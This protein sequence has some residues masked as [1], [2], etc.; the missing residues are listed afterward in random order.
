[1]KSTESCT[2][3][4]DVERGSG[5]LPAQAE[6]DE[7]RIEGTRHSSAALFCCQHWSYELSDDKITRLPELENTC[8]TSSFQKKKFLRFLN[9]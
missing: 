3:Q 1:M 2:D 7:A 5:E 6:T 4:L 9:H 8:A